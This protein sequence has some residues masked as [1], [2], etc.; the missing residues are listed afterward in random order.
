V[1]RD[2]GPQPR[3]EGGEPGT[4]VGGA[5]PYGVTFELL[6]G[7]PV[8]VLAP[9]G[10]D[11]VDERVAVTVGHAGQFAAFAGAGVVPGVAH[12]GEQRDDRGRGVEAD[13]VADAGVLGRVGGQHERDPPLPRR[14]VPEGGVPHGDARHPRGPLGVRDVAGQAVGAGLLE[15]ERDGDEAAVEFGYRDLGGGVQRGQPLVAA[16]P[17]GAG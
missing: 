11:R 1:A 13:R 16:S 5:D 10:D 6:L 4:V 12:R 17:L 8:L 15:G 9:R 7:K 14:D 2:R 3:V